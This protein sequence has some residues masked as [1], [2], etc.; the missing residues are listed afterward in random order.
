MFPRDR[1][2]FVC[3]N[4]R[5]DHAPKGSCAARG[6]EALY[7]RLRDLLRERGLAA[8]AARACSSSCLGLC[9][10]GPVIA[11]EPDHCFYGRVTREDLEE[12][13]DALV[14]SERVERLVVACDAPGRSP[15]GGRER[16][17]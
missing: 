6:S 9:E 1:F 2:L 11:V 14:R 4:R 3:V 15:G 13:V 17:G 16:G 10:S 12:I 5:P 8:R 7:A